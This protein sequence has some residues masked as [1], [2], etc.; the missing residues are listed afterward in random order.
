[1]ERSADLGRQMGAAPGPGERTARVIRYLIDSA[2]LWRILREPSLR[3][4]G[5]M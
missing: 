1:M 2:G 3:A 5:P 4:A